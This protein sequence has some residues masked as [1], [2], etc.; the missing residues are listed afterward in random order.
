VRAVG[1][2]QRRLDCEHGVHVR[3][4]A[5]ALVHQALARPCSPQKLG[6]AD[7]MGRARRRKGV[8]VMQAAEDR[9]RGQPH[10]LSGVAEDR[11]SAGPIESGDVMG[12]PRKKVARRWVKEL[13]GVGVLAS[14]SA[15][16]SNRPPLLAGSEA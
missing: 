11:A 12:I 15:C 14:G 8:P 16:R 5:A 2:R 9:D 3:D 10:P 7:W 6:N 4:L 13:N 1:R